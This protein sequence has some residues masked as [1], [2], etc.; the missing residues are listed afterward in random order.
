MPF[1]LRA[2]TLCRI[3][4]EIFLGVTPSILSGSIFSESSVGVPINVVLLLINAERRTT[5]F[6]SNSS[7]CVRLSD[8]S[9]HTFS[10][11]RSSVSSRY[12]MSRPMQES[13]AL[14]LPRRSS[15]SVKLE[16]TAPLIAVVPEIRWNTS[17]AVSLRR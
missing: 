4:L 1:F 15:T 12:S 10:P 11:L 5:I 2:S 8:T 9:S 6:P 3:S 17:S 16:S 14:P 13:L 7:G